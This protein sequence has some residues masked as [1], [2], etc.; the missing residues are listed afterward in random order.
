MASYN[1]SATSLSTIRV[2]VYRFLSCLFPPPL[3]I[4]GIIWQFAP[5]F[6]DGNGDSDEDIPLKYTIF[7]SKSLSFVHESL[8]L[9]PLTTLQ[10]TTVP[11]MH[12]FYMVHSIVTGASEKDLP[13]I[14]NLSLSDM[15]LDDV[16]E[17]MPGRDLSMENVDSYRGDKKFIV[18]VPSELFFK[19]RDLSFY[20]HHY[21]F[22]DQLKMRTKRGYIVLKLSTFKRLVAN[23]QLSTT[24]NNITKVEKNRSSA[25]GFTDNSRAIAFYN[26]CLMFKLLGIDFTCSQRV[27]SYQKIIYKNGHEYK[28]HGLPPGIGDKWYEEKSPGKCMGF[29]KSPRQMIHMA[30]FN[31][32]I[33]HLEDPVECGQ[34]RKFASLNFD[35]W[36]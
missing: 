19:H 21:E 27:D 7:F 36:K 6:L 29:L 34:K 9:S 18:L 1:Q 13:K 15:G 35:S 4:V 23:K 5:F 16:T 11:Y 31:K 14:Y 8:N 32:Q 17:G 20:V 2:K 26:T 30:F 28:K 3:P 10:N 25:V 22:V 24:V 12:T 33:K